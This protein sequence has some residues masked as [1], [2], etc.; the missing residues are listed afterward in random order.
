MPAAGGDLTITVKNVGRDTGTVTG[1]SCY[2]DATGKSGGGSASLVLHDHE[3]GTLVSHAGWFRYVTG[4]TVG[5]VT[6][7][8]AAETNLGNNRLE[9]LPDGL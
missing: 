9:V 5:G 3:E 6:A 2:Q 7:G 1:F 8:G 4:C